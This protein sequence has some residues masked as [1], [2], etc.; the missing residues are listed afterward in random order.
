MSLTSGGDQVAMAF[1]VPS[2]AV[3]LTSGG[4]SNSGASVSKTGLITIFDGCYVLAVDVKK[5]QKGAKDFLLCPVGRTQKVHNTS[6][7]E[8]VSSMDSMG[9]IIWFPK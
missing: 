1:L 3:I 4:H 8:A 6:E 7:Y 5:L 2:L 9:K